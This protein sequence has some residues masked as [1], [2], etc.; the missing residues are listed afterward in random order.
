MEREDP[1][2]GWVGPGVVCREFQ[3]SAHLCEPM[4]LGPC[5]DPELNTSS[6]WHWD[7]GT[8]QLPGHTM[9]HCFTSYSQN[10]LLPPFFLMS[11]FLIDGS[12]DWLIRIQSPALCSLGQT[13]WQDK[14]IPWAAPTVITWNHHGCVSICS[15]THI[16]IQCHCSHTK[17]WA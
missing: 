9:I 15:C 2:P 6:R 10:A 14:L 11:G 17:S 7:P 12:F 4:L 16:E 13:P 1:S 5:D 3:R 8:L